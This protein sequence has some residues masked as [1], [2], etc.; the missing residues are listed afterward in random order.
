MSRLSS[1]KRAQ[2]FLAGRLGQ[3][4][5]EPL[6]PAP[7]SWPAAQWA[8][9]T[10]TDEPEFDLD[11]RGRSP[12]TCPDHPGVR[13]EPGGSC[14]VCSRPCR[15][16]PGQDPPESPVPAPANPPRT[17]GDQASA[18]EPVPDPEPAHPDPGLA[19]QI[20]RSLQ[21]AG[22]ATTQPPPELVP[23]AHPPQRRDLLQSLRHRLSQAGPEPR[24]L[25]SS[26]RTR[27]RAE[28]VP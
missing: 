23:P 24:T 9:G 8:P 13:N 17:R 22:K 3:G 21:E 5:H 16:A 20:Q 19:Q 10:V 6:W 15:S 7:P 14:R 12:R 2:Q 25:R 28:A 26:N 4:V 11:S 27:G 1:L 18:P